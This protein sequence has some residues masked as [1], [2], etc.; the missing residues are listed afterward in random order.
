MDTRDVY[1]SKCGRT[2]KLTEGRAPTLHGQA[3][4][5]DGGELICLDYDD[6]C[7]EGECSVSGRPGIVMA[8]RLA[9]SHEK[10]GRWPRRLGTC[11]AC[12]LEAELERLSESL[13]FCTVCETTSAVERAEDVGD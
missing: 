1:C 2:V 10:D 4:L 3:T 5:Q 11:P 12:G 9:R 6:A 13:V 8:Y 7:S